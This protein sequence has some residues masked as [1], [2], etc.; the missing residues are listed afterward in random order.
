[1]YEFFQIRGGEVD[2]VDN[3]DA[4]SFLYKFKDVILCYF[5]NVVT[6]WAYFYLFLNIYT[7]NVK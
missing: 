4:E 6:V 1:M 5:I 7:L 3:I 2:L